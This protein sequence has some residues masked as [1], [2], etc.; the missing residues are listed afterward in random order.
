M[1]EVPLFLPFKIKSK[2]LRNRIVLS[3]MCQYKAIDGY[4]NDWHLQHY[5]RFGHHGSNNTGLKK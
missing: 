1:S 2:E 3:P 5:S 4:I